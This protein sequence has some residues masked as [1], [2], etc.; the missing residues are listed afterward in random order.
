MKLYLLDTGILTLFQRGHPETRQ[1]IA[2]HPPSHIAIPVISV[3]EE[4]T[5]WYTLLRKVRKR[6]ELAD[7][8][9]R[10]ADSVALF[11]RFSNPVVH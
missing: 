10:L 9:Q 11:A 2:A 1:H 7:V 5:G 8:Y 6:N 3:E 4:L